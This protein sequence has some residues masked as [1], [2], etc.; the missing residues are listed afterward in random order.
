M[1]YQRLLFAAEIRR[2]AFQM[3]HAAGFEFPKDAD[4]YPKYVRE[5]LEEIIATA[6]CIDFIQI[7]GKKSLD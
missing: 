1:D 4:E 5:A 6:D 2:L 3:F 7:Q